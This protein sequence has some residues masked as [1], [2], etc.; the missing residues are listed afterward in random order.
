MALVSALSCRL[1]GLLFSYIYL[2]VVDIIHI[3]LE[4]QSG[5]SR[6]TIAITC[7]HVIFACMFINI[8]YILLALQSRSS[9]AT[10]A[11]TCIHI[12]CI[13]SR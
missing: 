8:I 1:G 10:I 12:L 11:I 6:A 9:Q 7:M 4:L 3:W 2:Y 5:S 13:I